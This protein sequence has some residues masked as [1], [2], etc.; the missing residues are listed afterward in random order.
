[1]ANPDQLKPASKADLS[2]LANALARLLDPYRPSSLDADN[3]AEEGP[4]PIRKAFLYVLGISVVLWAATF[5][6][7]LLL[8]G[9]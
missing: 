2:G 1:L 4:W 7:F 6:G 3:M 8:F 5:A 9:P